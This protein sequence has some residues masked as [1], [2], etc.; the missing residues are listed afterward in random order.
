MGTD[1]EFLIDLLG[2]SRKVGKRNAAVAIAKVGYVHVRLTEHQMGD[3]RGTC[4]TVIV[5]L[6]PQLV[7]QPA[8]AAL[9][10]KLADLG[11]ERT[12]V[13]AEL[14]VPQSWVFPAHMP[15]L[16]MIAMLASDRIGGQAVAAV[17]LCERPI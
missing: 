3:Q 2:R 14:A 11:P 13:L 8:I 17:D 16:R 6:Q 9:G 5:T 1:V 12:I 4:Q 10:Y 15:A 7:T